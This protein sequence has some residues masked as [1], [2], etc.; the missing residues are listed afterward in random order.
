MGPELT[1]SIHT[2]AGRLSQPSMGLSQQ[3]LHSPSAKRG[4]KLRI[5][6]HVRA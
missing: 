6:L 5:S 1:L 2:G 3:N 4:R